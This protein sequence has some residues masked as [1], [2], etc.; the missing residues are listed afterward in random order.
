MRCAACG[1]DL[2][3][4]ER[5]CQSCGRPVDAASPSVPA[6]EP[7]S[8]PPP[9]VSAGGAASA[10]HAREVANAA[11]PGSGPQ[12]RWR[13][14]AWTVL[15]LVLYAVIA[16]VAVETFVRGSPLR[17]WI[18]G[19]AMAYLALCLAAWRLSPNQWHRLS[20]PHRA[21]ISV[22]VLVAGIGVTAWLPMGSLKASGF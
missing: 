4:G 8:A 18:A 1:H 7:T 11:S 17:W 3:A 16:D 6:T 5:F 2:I 21:G 9:G 13:A 14:L 12:A 20:W 15:G 10:G 19:S 22:I